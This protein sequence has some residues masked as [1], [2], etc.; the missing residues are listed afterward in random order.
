[1]IK[2]CACKQWYRRRIDIISIVKISSLFNHDNAR[3][4]F[5]VI[6]FLLVA[7]NASNIKEANSATEYFFINDYFL[8]VATQISLYSLH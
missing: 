3:L 2:T 4:F 7:V 5:S 6:F 1:M 8:S